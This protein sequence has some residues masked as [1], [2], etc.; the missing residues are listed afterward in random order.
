MQ[1]LSPSSVHG[2]QACSAPR[3]A[4]GRNRKG[5]QARQPS[6][7][8]THPPLSPE[9]RSASS[10]LAAGGQQV[11]L[12]PRLC[13][14]GRTGQC[15]TPA[16]AD[17]PRGG[18][19]SVRGLPDPS[20]GAGITAVARVPRC[21]QPG[22][23]ASPVSI[24]LPRPPPSDCGQ[25]SVS[26]RGVDRTGDVWA[27]SHDPCRVPPGTCRPDFCPIVRREYT[28]GQSSG[29]APA[30]LGAQWPRRRLRGKNSRPRGLSSVAG[31]GTPPASHEDRGPSAESGAWRSGLV[32]GTATLSPA[33]PQAPVC[34]CCYLR[35]SSYSYKHTPERSFTASIHTLPA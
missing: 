27:I 24:A 10:V 16:A 1:E 19:G 26:G 25:R 9:P 28:E 3:A 30:T 21:A 32:Q 4:L 7:P 6:E 35:C 18:A 29:Q 5:P 17:R 2:F 33:R 11:A 23:L 15:R 34:K 13:G 14:S 8:R 22:L 31:C 20:S 12:G